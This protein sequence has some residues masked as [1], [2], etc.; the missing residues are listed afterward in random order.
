MSKGLKVHLLIIDPQND[1]M[2]NDD[3]TPLVETLGTS[4]VRTAA[5]PVKGAVSDM[6]RAAKMIDRIGHKLDD[7]KVTLDSHRRIGIERP[8][9][10]MNAKGKQPAPFTIISVSDIEAGIW[11]PRH[12]G[13]R[14]RALAYAK[15]LE[16]G[17]LYPLMIWT[18]HCEIGTWGHNVQD[19]L[20]D[21]LQ[22]WSEK[23]FASVDY[24]TKGSNPHT[25]HFG[26]L[27]AE[28]PDPDD[29]STQLNTSVLESLA[30]ADIIGALGEASSHCLL[31]TM[32]QIAKNIGSEHLNKF[33]LITDCMSPV[34]AVPNGPDFPAIADAWQKD[35]QKLGMT[36]ITSTDF[37]T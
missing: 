19:D 7:I 11:T 37:L 33:A 1:F 14:A 29:P 24:V 25:E 32:N 31:T 27:M 2:G 4:R 30:E 20:N 8:G 17:G 9:Y 22:R 35:M 3:G 15:A 6:K 28:V 13:L 18:N 26:A 21:A 16:A 36:L 12:P 34:G 23:E 10:W 5:L